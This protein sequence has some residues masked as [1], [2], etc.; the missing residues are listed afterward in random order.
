[1]DY[2]QLIA[3]ALHEQLS[4]QLELN[5]IKDL[6]EKPKHSD[7]GDVAFP[8]FQLAKI[9]RKNPAQIAQD[10]G[11]SISSPLIED[12]QIVGPYINFFLKKKLYQV[13]F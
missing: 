2:K 8:T 11:S 1:M 7:H 10:I 4:E 12:K 5:E 3:E 9:F 6:L 13:L